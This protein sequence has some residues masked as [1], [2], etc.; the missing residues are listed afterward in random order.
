MYNTEQ[1]KEEEEEKKGRNQPVGEVGNS[2]DNDAPLILSRLR[3][4]NKK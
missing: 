3:R 4:C 2:F 1:Y